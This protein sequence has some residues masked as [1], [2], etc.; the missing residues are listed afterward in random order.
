MDVKN[1]PEA[2]RI[3]RKLK[4]WSQEQVG[5]EV[6]ASQQTVAGWEK[7]RSNPRPEAYAKLVEVFGQDSLVAQFPPKDEDLQPQQIRESRVRFRMPSLDIKPTGVDYLRGIASD[8]VR[9]RGILQNKAA[10]LANGK[11]ALGA[12]FLEDTMAH[13]SPAFRKNFNFALTRG[14]GPN[15]KDYVVDYLSDTLCIEVKAVSAAPAAPGAGAVAPAIRAADAGVRQLLVYKA[16]LE[17]Q[18]REVPEHIILYL[19]DD[20]GGLSASPMSWSR[21]TFEAT[22]LGIEVRHVGSPEH[23]ADDIERMESGSYW[24]DMLDFDEPTQ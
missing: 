20:L 24:A 21:I 16:I 10:L 7:G 9:F 2:L 8:A 19:V 1:F 5:T 17:R 4:D 3:C 13:V 12:A 18:G 23:L 11:T 15:T 22:M 6:G 14:F